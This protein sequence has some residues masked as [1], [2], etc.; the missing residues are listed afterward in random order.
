MIYYLKHEW[1]LL[2]SHSR[3]EFFIINRCILTRESHSIMK[4]DYYFTMHLFIMYLLG[5]KGGSALGSIPCFWLLLS[6]APYVFLVTLSPVTHPLLFFF[7]GKQRSV[8][9]HEC[10]WSLSLLYFAAIK[11]RKTKKH[12]SKMEG[13]SFFP[14]SF[15]MPRI[16]TFQFFK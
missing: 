4:Y 15:F 14:A 10:T 1:E 6:S 16:M 3:R 12:F 13:R 11:P 9:F 5:F 7:L 8:C 2:N